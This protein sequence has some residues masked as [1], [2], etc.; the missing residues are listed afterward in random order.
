MVVAAATAAAVISRACGGPGGG[1]IGVFG[2][3]GGGGNDCGGDCG[4]GD[5][6]GNCGGAGGGDCGG[7]ACAAVVVRSFSA[8]FPELTGQEGAIRALVAEEEA[9]FSKMLERGIKF[10]GEV[11]D[12]QRGAGSDVIPGDKVGAWTQLPLCNK[13]RRRTLLGCVA[14][15]AAD[16]W[17]GRAVA[18]ARDARCGHGRRCVVMCVFAWPGIR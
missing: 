7:G 17:C 16:C 8:A 2:I 15:A 10:L 1:G 12:E 3:G 13:S 4:G 5:Y 11:Q 18:A 6:G 14:A 9:S